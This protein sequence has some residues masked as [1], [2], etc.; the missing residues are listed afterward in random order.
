MSCIKAITFDLWNTLIHNKNYSEYRLSKLNEMLCR[1]GPAPTEKELNS[2]YM[3]GWAHSSELKKTEKNLHVETTEI[4]RKVLENAGLSHQPEELMN[5]TR[6]YEE[7]IL[8]APPRLKDGVAETLRAL[9]GRYKMGIISDTGV[10]PGRIMRQVLK[11]LGISHYFDGFTFSDEVGVCKPD[12][13]I[14][15]QALRELDVLPSETIHVG[16]LIRSDVMGAKMMGMKAVWIM[17]REQEIKEYVPDY[18]VSKI[19][20]ILEFL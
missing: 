7:A 1:Y 11:G 10:S 2:L 6:I 12:M 19:G 20:E 15:R 5:L 17:T 18:T 3:T 13:R 16:D 8:E 14:F 4:T 9:E